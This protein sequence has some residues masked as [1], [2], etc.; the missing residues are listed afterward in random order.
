[1]CGVPQSSVQ[2]SI[3]FVLFTTPL[4]DI[5]AITLGES[6]DFRG[7]HTAPEIRSSRWSDQRQLPPGMRV[8]TRYINSTRSTSPE[9]MPPSGI[10]TL[11]FRHIQQHRCAEAYHQF[12]FKTGH[13]HLISIMAE[14]NYNIQVILCWYF[15]LLFWTSTLS[16]LRLTYFKCWLQASM[17]H[18]W[19]D[20]QQPCLIGTS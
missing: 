20:E 5:I 11:H 14:H 10:Y 13:N 3:H 12:L 2:G 6:S 4:S 19:P 1:M 18:R 8:N 17:I 15:S 16:A 9:R 7:W